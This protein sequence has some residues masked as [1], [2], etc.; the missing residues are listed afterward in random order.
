MHSCLQAPLSFWTG[1]IEP[2]AF[3]LVILAGAQRCLLRRNADSAKNKQGRHRAVTQRYIK[4]S[5]GDS[6]PLNCCKHLS[7]EREKL[8]AICG[9]I[10]EGLPSRPCLAPCQSCNRRVWRRRKK[11]GKI[12]PRRPSRR[13]RCSSLTED[14]DGFQICENKLQSVFL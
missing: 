1:W 8:T 11:K 5:A 14:G 10:N 7:P 12:L 13:Q 6:S 3:W 9:Q 4:A 2:V